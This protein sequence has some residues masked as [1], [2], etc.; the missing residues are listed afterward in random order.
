MDKIYTAEEVRDL[1]KCSLTFVYKH[2]W[3]L[4][5]V[6]V[7]TLIRFPE[8]GLRGFL[9]VDMESGKKWWYRFR[10]Q[11]ESI[12]SEKG[13]N[14]Q[15]D[16]RLAQAQKHVELSKTN[17]GSVW[18]SSGSARV[19]CRSYGQKGIAFTCWIIRP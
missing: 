8:S 1:P 4:G 9:D 7:G 14:N 11:G 5:A 2:K 15:Q 13:Y 3:E 12:L 10:W 17:R 6:R 18:T 16:A 19:A